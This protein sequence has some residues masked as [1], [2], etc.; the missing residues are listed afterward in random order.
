MNSYRRTSSLALLVFAIAPKVLAGCEGPDA[1]RESEDEDTLLT[2]VEELNGTC[3][4]NLTAYRGQNNT[5]VSCSCGPASTSYVWG[6]DVYT[7]DSRLCTAA[8]HAGVIPISGGPI[9]ATILPGQDHYDATTQNGVT[10]LSYGSWNGSYS[11]EAPVVE[12]PPPP[13][14]S[15]AA[16][17]SS[18]LQY[19][20]QL[21]TQL[22]CTCAPVVPKSVWGTGIYTDD[23]NV[24]TAAV[25]AGSIPMSGGSVIAI[26]LPGQA[27]YQGSTQNG[28]TSWAYGQWHGSFITVPGQGDNDE[29]VG[30]AGGAGGES[31]ASSAN[32]SGGAGGT[33]GNGGG[34]SGGAGGA[35]GSG[36]GGSGGAVA[37]Y[38]C[39][40]RLSLNTSLDDL[41]INFQA[42]AWRTTAL[43]ILNRRY[44][45]GKY[46]VDQLADPGN[47][48]FWFIH[49]TDSFQKVVDG[50]PAAVHESLHM[51]GFEENTANK[52]TWIISTN[53]RWTVTPRPILF[54]RSEILDVLPD[55]EQT[56]DYAS[57]YLTGASGAQDIELLLEELNAYTVTLYVARALLDQKP[58]NVTS[59]MRDGMLTLMLYTEAYLK[60]AA[61]QYPADYQAITGNA[62]LV[63]VIRAMWSRAVCL[64]ELT[65]NFPQLGIRDTEIRAHVYDPSWLQHIE[66]L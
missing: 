9:V 11:V 24:C 19:R 4:Y 43:E 18:M 21:G 48:D 45:D 6:T 37:S 61:E 36:A 28:I 60:V 65:E 44:A 12:P 42:A 30:D 20:G 29:P 32:G 56:A 54:N 31:G 59:S 22:E 27:S 14:P 63:D 35:A 51:A 52:Y 57:T 64:D 55:D 1:Y 34:G 53:T 13:P 8:V 3:P 62:Q 49:G 40:S 15:P 33:S 26:V 17:P 7:D 41:K 46:I 58:P 66:N 5:K 39:A 50:L 23:S 25:H 10:S 38:D 16:C 47:F 2:S